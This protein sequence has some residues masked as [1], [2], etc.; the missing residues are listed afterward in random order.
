MHLIEITTNYFINTHQ[1]V[2]IQ[3]TP[4]ST[5]IRKKKNNND[6]VDSKEIKTESALT[7]ILTSGDP[8]KHS[9]DKADLLYKTLK[10]K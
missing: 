2:S 6:D 3:Y 5:S 7:I 1:I 8:I 10:S 9:G 4:A